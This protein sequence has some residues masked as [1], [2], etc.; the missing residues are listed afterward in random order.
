MRSARRA[1]WLPVAVLAAVAA[2][3][4]PQAVQGTLRFETFTSKV[5]GNTRTLR[6]LLPP[7]YDAPSY[8]TRVYPVLYLNDGQNLF[9]P[10]TSTFTGLEWR[11]DE[12]VRDLVSTGQFPEIIVVGI[13]HAG[14]NARFHEYFPYVDRYLQPP[15]PDPQGKRY[16]EFLV[17]EVV[18]FIEGKYRVAGS[19][20]HRG[21][22]GSSAGALAA[23][24][25][26]IKRPGVFGRLLAE[27]PSIYVD[28]ARILKEAAGVTT[29]PD[30]IF[31]GAG[32]NESGRPSCDPKATEEPDIVTDARRFLALTKGREGS[33][34]ALQI[35]PCG[36]HDEA[37][38]AH[39]LPDALLFLYAHSPDPPRR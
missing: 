23:I 26:V 3:P 34:T 37:A 30:R 2:A 29:W 5:F 20:A 7:S 39:R 1:W 12:V 33:G 38:W 35:T 14:R 27:S 24:Y 16:P 31:V 6:V 36:R 22:G 21:I 10:A 8:R 15:D 25:A 28:D 11:V 32:T 19:P 9:D 4:A 18:P 13:D 17:D